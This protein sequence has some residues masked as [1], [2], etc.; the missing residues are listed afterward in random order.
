MPREVA[1]P[2]T[3]EYSWSLVRKEQGSVCGPCCGAA[4]SQCRTFQS[5]RPGSNSASRARRGHDH[6]PPLRTQV[7]LLLSVYNVPLTIPTMRAWKVLLGH[8]MWVFMGLR[9]LGTKHRPFFPPKGT[10]LRWRTESN[11]VW[12]VVGSYFVSALLF[13]VADLCNQ[14]LLPSSI[15]D[16]ESVVSKLVN[17]ENKDL[18]AMAVGV[19]PGTAPASVAL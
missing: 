14:F 8:L 2:K 4:L 7:L 18:L 1:S 17:P 19:T 11:W 16:E 15:F 13:N 12:W 5:G 10:W 9:I 3:A 6:I